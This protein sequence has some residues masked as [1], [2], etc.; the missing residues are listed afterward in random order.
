VEF[1]RRK[2]EWNVKIRRQENQLVKLKQINFDLI[3]KLK[4]INLQIDELIQQA[5]VKNQID[6]MREHDQGIVE[7]YECDH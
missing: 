1:E 3:G 5:Q 6:A 7:Q 2:N 4:Q